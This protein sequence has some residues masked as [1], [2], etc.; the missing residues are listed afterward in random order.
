MST[1]G[2]TNF[3]ITRNELITDA[4]MEIKMLGA[5]ETVLSADFDYCNRKLNAMVKAWSKKDIKLF[6]TLNAT[7]F[8]D[9][10]T[11]SYTL[12][13]TGDH[14]SATVVS[15]A[16]AAAG[17]TS[18]TS[19]TVDSTTGMTV[20]DYIG[21]ALD[22]GIRHWTTIATLP[23]SNVITLTAGLATAAAEDNTV[24]TYTTRLPRPIEIL[25]IRRVDAE[26]TEKVMEI[27]SR[28]EY[29]QI[30]I[31]STASD[32]SVF[33][34]DQQLTSGELY[35][36]PVSDS[37][38]NRLILT[39]RRQLDDFDNAADNPDFPPEWYEALVLNLAARLA[40]PYA[41]PSAQMDRL[42][43]DALD[44]LREAIES[45]QERAPVNMVPDI[46]R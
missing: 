26:G 38:E 44:A 43:V 25:S 27:Y 18:A 29:E 37:I 19:I 36:W 32:P 22:S 41:L 39:C 3:T 33:Y 6:A 8:L 17:A 28:Q 7:V 40:R 34:Y 2:S 42:K 30:A 5:E 9:E 4:L 20:G 15:T 10:D 35:I 1:S 12:S 11:Q 21:I 31:K 13:S 14:A 16:L 23:G 46:C 24:Y 45:D